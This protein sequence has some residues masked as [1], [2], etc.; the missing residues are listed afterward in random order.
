MKLGTKSLLWGVH[1]F[2]WHPCC[3]LRAWVDLYGRPSPWE[4][5][6]IVIHDWGY[7]GSPNI[8]G[9]EGENHTHRSKH[10]MLFLAELCSPGAQRELAELVLL[11]S[12]RTAAGRG[13]SPSRLCWA[14]KLAVKYD[15][16]WFFVLRAT[17]SGEIRE[18]ARTRSCGLTFRNA[19]W[20]GLGRADRLRR[21]DQ[22]REL[23]KTCRAE[24]ASFSGRA[25]AVARPSKL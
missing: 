19:N 20:F 23:E 22:L 25:P 18:F 2:L 7:W 13:T 12:R 15:P 21:V 10:V 16:D 17:L 5:V 4:L 3:V 8:D 14:D 24:A 11:H 9:P 6:A 1:Q